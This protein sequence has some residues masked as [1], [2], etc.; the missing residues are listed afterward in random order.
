MVFEELRSPTLPVPSPIAR[1]A[2]HIF[3]IRDE[4]GQV[5]TPRQDLPGS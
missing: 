4:I 1:A 5:V 3:A 2:P